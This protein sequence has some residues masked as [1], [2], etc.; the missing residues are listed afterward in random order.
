MKHAIE[1]LSDAMLW[2]LESFGIQIILIE[3]GA[4]PTHPL[5][6]RAAAANARGRASE[7]QHVTQALC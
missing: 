6:A 1:A 2:E 3:P 5:Y 7:S 4:I